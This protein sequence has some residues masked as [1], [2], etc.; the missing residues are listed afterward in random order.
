MK[1]SGRARSGQDRVNLYVDFILNIRLI[2][3]EFVG[4]LIS[5]HVRLGWV[6]IGPDQFDL[7]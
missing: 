6:R 5:D 1:E 7:L 2:S 3:I 4:H